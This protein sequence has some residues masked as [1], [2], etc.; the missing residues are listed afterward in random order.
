[1]GSAES[2]FDLV[3]IHDKFRGLIGSRHWKEPG[4]LM[5]NLMTDAMAG[6]KNGDGT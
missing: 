6:G 3:Q 5:S 2:R 1:M 4:A